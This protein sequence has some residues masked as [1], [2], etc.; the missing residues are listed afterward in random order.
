VY[1]CFLDAHCW[2]YHETLDGETCRVY[3]TDWASWGAWAQI[4]AALYLAG[5]VTWGDEWFTDA[6][7]GYRLSNQRRERGWVGER[8]IVIVDGISPHSERARSLE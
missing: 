6:P 5:T 3:G 8:D 7:V 1:V 4:N 2:P